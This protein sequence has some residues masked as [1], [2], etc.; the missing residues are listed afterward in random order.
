MRTMAQK[1][2]WQFKKKKKKGQRVYRLGLNNLNAVLGQPGLESLHHLCVK[3]EEN[4]IEYVNSQERRALKPR[5]DIIQEEDDEQHKAEQ[6]EGRVS[7]EGPPGD[8]KDFPR[9]QSTYSDHKQNLENSCA[10]Y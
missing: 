6:V 9:E 10:H 8:L 4:Q 2:Q 3:L 5:H 7:Q 1:Q